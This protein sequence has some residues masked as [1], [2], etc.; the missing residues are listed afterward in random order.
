M[1]K[2]IGF[3]QFLTEGARTRAVR[4][5]NG[6]AAWAKRDMQDIVSALAKA[7]LAVV[8]MEVW[9]VAADNVEE[10][11]FFRKPSN[12]LEFMQPLGPA[13]DGRLI[14]GELPTKDGQETVLRMRGHNHPDPGESWEDF[15]AGMADL[16]LEIVR[17][18]ERRIIP[19]LADKLF[20]EI[21][22]ESRG[23]S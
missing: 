5:A 7:N 9:A 6:E 8:G 21:D 19:G 3:E 22:V 15:V 1:L 23:E 14:W 18:S 12:P 16:A 10:K 20:Y 11:R 2:P 17:E 4:L 13:L